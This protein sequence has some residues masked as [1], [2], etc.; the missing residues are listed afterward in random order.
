MSA[1]IVVAWVAAAAGIGA[2][3]VAVVA[4]R[5]AKATVDVSRDQLATAREQ[6]VLQRQI[7]QDAAQPALWVDIRPDDQSSGGLI[8]FVGN[9]GP[10]VATDVVVTFDPDLGLL[11]NPSRNTPPLAA[12]QLRRG[13]AALPPGR[14]LRWFLG[15]ANQVIPAF[16]PAGGYD[17]TITGT[18][19]FGVAADS[20]ATEFVG[21]AISL[22]HPAGHAPRNQGRAGCVYRQDHEVH[23]SGGNSVQAGT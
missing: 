11:P 1:E 5:F 4:L 2:T 20:S 17:V 23:R 6:T 8:L 13:I 15:V 12:E 9:S 14:T 18:G 10:S 19:P 7:Q 22:G 3:V 16:D 21:D